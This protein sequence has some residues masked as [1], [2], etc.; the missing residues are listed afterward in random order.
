M[1]I[2]VVYKF[3]GELD[4][5]IHFQEKVKQSDADLIE[6]RLDYCDPK[7]LTINL[8]QNLRVIKS[9]PLILTLR[10]EKEGGEKHFPL[11]RKYEIWEAIFKLGF[12]YIDIELSTI[13]ENNINIESIRQNSSTKVIFSY[14]NFQ[15]SEKYEKLL[16]F[17]N[18]MYEKGADI[19]K[20]VVMYENE[21]T[22]QDIL[23]LI[24]ETR[25]ENK[26]IIAIV[27]G[28]EGKVTRLEGLKVGSYLTY[29]TIDNVQTAP[30]QVGVEEVKEYLKIHK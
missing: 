13:L 15:N 5:F 3:N 16:D 14:H 30:G 19:S 21:R 23:K 24:N 2:A 12:E 7:I 22:N 9:M 6:L 1:K 26:E 18:K 28:E 20:L 29:A 17:R 27:M 25:K 10:S 4:D 8:L 11:D